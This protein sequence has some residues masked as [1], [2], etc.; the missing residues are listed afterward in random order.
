M[1]IQTFQRALQFSSNFIVFITTNLHFHSDC[2]GSEGSGLKL[3][4]PKIGL[5][6]GQKVNFN[7]EIERLKAEVVKAKKTLYHATPGDIRRGIS[8]IRRICRD[9][10]ISRVYG[11][12]IE[13]LEC[14]ENL[15][16]AVE[17]TAG[18]RSTFFLP[19]FPNLKHL[20][21]VLGVWSNP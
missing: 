1:N 10:N 18:N 14:D 11:S 9:Y 8:C 12:I 2:E 20:E 21:K 19:H 17:V 13:L 3:H 15:F 4:S 6:G 5:C 7:A 16:T